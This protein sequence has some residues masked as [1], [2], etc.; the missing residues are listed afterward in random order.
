MFEFDAPQIRASPITGQKTSN[1][2]PGN[3]SPYKS[4]HE[5]KVSSAVWKN[6]KTVVFGLF[7]LELPTETDEW[8]KRAMKQYSFC[9]A[10]LAFYKGSRAL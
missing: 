9:F 10:T 5:Y 1:W 4:D 7:T 8:K 3:F 6:I 2:H